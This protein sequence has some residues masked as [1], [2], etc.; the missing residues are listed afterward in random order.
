MF[1]FF[2]CEVIC[3]DFEVTNCFPNLKNNGF[4]K[5]ILR[6]LKDQGFVLEDC[7][8]SFLVLCLGYVGVSFGGPG[9][10]RWIKLGLQI[11]VF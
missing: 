11:R 9:A 3:V 6:F 1:F 5:E 10:L 4:S 7:S 8:G 2:F